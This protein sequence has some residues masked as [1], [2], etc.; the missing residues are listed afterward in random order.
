[1]PA[2]LSEL[3][4]RI[5][6]HFYQEPYDKRLTRRVIKSIFS[7]NSIENY[8]KPREYDQLPPKD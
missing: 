6:D 2:R 1:M 7:K 5:S 8:L 4:D 3:G